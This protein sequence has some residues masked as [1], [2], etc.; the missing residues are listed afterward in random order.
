MLNSST[1]TTV[2]ATGP[3]CFP[4]KLWRIVFWFRCHA[5]ERAE[6]DIMNVVDCAI[7]FLCVFVLVR[8]AVFTAARVTKF[9]LREP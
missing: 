5:L 7:D 1:T 3:N 9:R 2:W 6:R 8:A 4:S